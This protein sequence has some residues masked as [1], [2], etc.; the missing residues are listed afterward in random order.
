MMNN[1]PNCPDCGWQLKR[2]DGAFIFKCD[3]CQ[4]EFDTADMDEATHIEI[5]ASFE[6]LEKLAKWNAW[7]SKK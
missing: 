4:Q 2:G 1:M 6:D 3:G 7:A 5:K